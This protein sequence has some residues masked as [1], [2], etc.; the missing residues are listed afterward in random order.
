MNVAS[1]IY[2]QVIFMLLHDVASYVL[3]VSEEVCFLVSDIG[4]YLQYR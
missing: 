4:F 1:Q 2:V 3:S